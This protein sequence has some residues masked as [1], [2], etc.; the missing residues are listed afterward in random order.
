MELIKRNL[1]EETVV[2]FQCEYAPNLF[3]KLEFIVSA[4]GEQSSYALPD[5]TKQEIVAH[6]DFSAIHKYDFLIM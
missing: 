5:I 1:K 4:A 3:D 2:N 6:F